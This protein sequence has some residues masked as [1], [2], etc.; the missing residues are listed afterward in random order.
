M[1]ED[2]TV[3]LTYAELAEARGVS[4]GAAKR[5]VYRHRWQKQIGNDGLSHILVPRAFVT[6][7]PVADDVD[8]DVTGNV[9]GNV[10]ADIIGDRPELRV[11]A[12]EEALS[13][14]AA[15]TRDVIGD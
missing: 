6:R 9:T 3:R 5:L 12:L 2:D 14:L 8:D 7:D 4:L 10:G 1:T 11:V 15:V 13:V